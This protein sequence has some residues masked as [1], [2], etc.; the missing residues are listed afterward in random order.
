MERERYRECVQA[1]GCLT[2][3]TDACVSAANKKASPVWLANDRLT[4]AGGGGSMRQTM[5]GVCVNS[6]KCITTSR[7]PVI[8]IVFGVDD[9]NDDHCDITS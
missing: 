6:E 7:A 9:D 8:V 4:A 5:F 3:S 1:V 2:L